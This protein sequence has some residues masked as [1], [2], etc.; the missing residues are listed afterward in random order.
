MTGVMLNEKGR[1]STA[2]NYPI[3]QC[4]SC[5]HYK[6]S[7]LKFNNE[8]FYSCEKTANLMSCKYEQK[9]TL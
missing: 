4:A 7:G 5:K 1:T 6:D 2:V 3:N 9:V 8:V